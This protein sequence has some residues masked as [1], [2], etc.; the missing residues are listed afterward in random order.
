MAKQVRFIRLEVENFAGLPSETVTYGDITAFS[1]MNGEGKT[2]LGTAPVWTLYGVDLYGS[3]YNPTPTTYEYD[4]VHVSLLMSVDDA[5]LKFAREINAKGTNV[6]FLNDVPA[7][8]KEFEEAV[9]SLFDKDEFLSL[10]NPVYFFTQHWTKQREQI[11]KYS[12]PPAK[13]EVFAE[14]SRTSADQKTKDIK[15]NPQAVKLA[16]LTKKHSLDDLQKIHGGTG[17]QKSK[18]EKQSIAAQSRTKTLVEQLQR[19]PA[20][21]SDIEALKTQES[22]LREKIA[23]I[24]GGVADAHRI[25]NKRIELVCRITDQ[26]DSIKRSKDKFLILHGETIEENCRTCK[27]PLNAEAIEATKSDK[28]QRVDKARADHQVLIDKRTELETELAEIVVVDMSEQQAQVR[29]LEDQLDPVLAAIRNE[30]ERER[31]QADVD[32]AKADEA[33]TLA[34]LKESVFI[35]DAIKSYRA[36]EAELQ[37]DKVQSLFTTLKIRLFKHVKTTG[38]YEPDFSIQSNNKDYVQ[39]STGQR[40]G[41]GLELSEF[42]FK[43]SELIVPTFID[44]IGE[45]T[46]KVAVYGQLITGRAVADQELKIESEVVA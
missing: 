20:S 4:R 42:F 16:E 17:G 14:M 9:A 45:Y 6:F 3:K 34:S 35:L 36:K 11:L 31:L 23:E 28:Q 44:S 25:N 43:Q 33:D 18:L 27:Q 2:S 40:V 26:S 5:E 39:L 46:G 12:T 30:T 13:S 7:K 32:K 38:E 10:Y 37:A 24:D 15:H 29:V 19:Y 1:G 41:A 21:G 22:A 8:A